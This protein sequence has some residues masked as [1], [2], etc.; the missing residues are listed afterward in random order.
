MDGYKVLIADDELLNRKLLQRFLDDAGY[1]SVMVDDGDQVMPVLKD[2]PDDFDLI[3]LDK[4]MPRLD[5]FEVLKAI[6]ADSQFS[7]I[8]IV[9]QTAAIE[10]ESVIEGL[11]LGAYYYLPK[12]FEPEVLCAILQAALQ[13]KAALLEQQ[14]NIQIG[15]LS[16]TLQQGIFKFQTLQE[17]DDIAKNN[18]ALL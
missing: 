13:E 3:L 8:P 7:H 14:K 15:T 18:C 2:N 10:K 16:C 4:M 6:R 12:P 5:G 17:G 9:M 11:E 1:Q